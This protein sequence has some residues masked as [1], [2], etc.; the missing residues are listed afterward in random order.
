MATIESTRAEAVTSPRLSVVV[1][2]KNVGLWIGQTVESILGQTFKDLEL[3]LV[4]DGSDDDTIER[5]LESAAGDPRLRIVPNPEPGGARARNLA[6][7]MSKGTYL[8]FADG[9]DIV[10]V[11]AYR[12]MIDQAERTGA[13]MVVGNH[14]VL[15]PQRITTRNQS[16]PIYKHVREGITVR[17]EPLFLR[18]RVCWNRIIRR[19]SWNEFGLAF[20][21]SRRSN[22]IGAMTKAYAAFSFDV[23]P[24]PV[25]GYR[26]RVGA[27]SM[28]S[29]KHQPGPLQ[30]HFTQELDCYRT[31]LGLGD[32]RLL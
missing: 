24:E 15:E 20:A 12:T 32:P 7:G 30:D 1:P 25:Y 17:D 5:A 3:I 26:R 28:T 10:P 2:A 9:D 6:I 16:L 31:V 13:E 8:A 23:V 21:E 11:G 19:E 18:D 29:A 4:D 27:T 14:M 22:D